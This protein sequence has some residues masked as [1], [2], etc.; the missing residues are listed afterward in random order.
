[1]PKKS[2]IEREYESY[3]NRIHLI[4]NEE[5]KKIKREVKKVKEEAE[6]VGKESSH[7]ITDKS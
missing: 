6:K 5:I 4:A 2:R 7:S 1:M 3:K